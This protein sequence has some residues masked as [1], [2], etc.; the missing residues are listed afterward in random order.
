VCFS[1]V[2]PSEKFTKL[3]LALRRNKIARLADSIDNFEF[4]TPETGDNDC[5][6]LIGGGVDLT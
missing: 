4:V 2:S 3:N 6:D 5:Y 1:P